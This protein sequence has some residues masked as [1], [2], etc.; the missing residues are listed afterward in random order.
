V[1]GSRCAVAIRNRV[2][3]QTERA[4]R[5]PDWSLAGLRYDPDPAL[6]QGDMKTVRNLMWH[7]VGLLRNE[8]RLGRAERDL[9]Y[10]RWEVES[11]YRKT[12]L[13]DDLIGLRNAIQAALIITYAA[14]KNRRSLGCHYREDGN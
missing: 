10:L 9:R 13:S 2:E 5:V 8:Y 7:Y 12:R 14:K 6:I 1:W 3:T 4:S 11:F